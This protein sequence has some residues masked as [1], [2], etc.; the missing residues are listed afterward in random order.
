VSVR[1][2]VAGSLSAQQADRAAGRPTGGLACP[3]CR[4]PRSRTAFEVRGYVFRRCRACASLFLETAPP[5]GLLSALY[6]GERYFL[7]PEYESGDYFG[8][9][10]YLADRVHIEEKFDQVLAQAERL[11]DPGRLLD[12]GAGPGLLLAAAR[13]HGWEPHGVDLN[14]W[15][16]RWARDQLGVDVQIGSLEEAGLEPASFDAVTMMDVIEHVSDPD[17]LVAEAAQATRPG[18]V[19]A[20]LTA[21]AG[22]PTTR[23]L[24]RR[25]PEV[26][27][28]EEHVVLFSVAG[29]GAL[30][31]RHSFE[32]LG[33]H[34]IGKRSS[35]ATLAADL[36]PIAPRLAPVLRRAV[37]GRRIALRTFELDPRAKFCL[38]AR[39]SVPEASIR[40]MA[41]RHLRSPPRI[42]KQP[43]GG[44]TEAIRHDLE[45]VAGAPRLVHW[46]FEQFEQLVH[47]SV[48]EV[49]AGIGTFSSRILAAGVEHLLLIEPERSCA[50]ALER[51]FDV[52]APVRVARERLPEAPSLESERFDLVVCQNVLEHV[53]DDVASLSTMAAALRPGAPLVLIVPAH[54]RLFGSLDLS[55]GHRRRYTAGGLREMIEGAELSVVDLYHFNLLGVLGWWTKGRRPGGRISARSM[56][57]YD[58]M[59]ALWRPLER[60]ARPP[61]G[62]SLVAHARRP[63]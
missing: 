35:L 25:W 24:G 48:A 46:T 57:A 26:Q 44:I 10:D 28:A 34:S 60:L 29:L 7:N 2:M 55:Y 50:D 1:P 59:L 32:P 22:S 38:Y 19:L 12:V 9:R 36:A 5:Q 49:G 21:D 3:A 54:P 16:A 61:W 4:S 41:R 37:G 43:P 17:T 42:R 62:L 39:R 14:P 27:R 15:A 18:G 47:G 40:Q 8:Y 20:V 56:A 31:A 52:N 13:S 6:E 53:D 63:S 45:H 23:L 51:R 33:W 30:L 11:V 58:R